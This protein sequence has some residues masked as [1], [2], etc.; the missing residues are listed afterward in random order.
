MKSFTKGISVKLKFLTVFALT[1]LSAE[2]VHAQCSPVP[3]ADIKAEF[4]KNQRGEIFITDPDPTVKYHWYRDGDMKDM[5]YGIDGSGRHLVTS[6]DL[7]AAESYW[8]KK[9]INSTIGPGVIAQNNG[10]SAP[11]D[12]DARTYE[13]AFDA[14][15]DFTLNSVKVP[16]L[17]YQNTPTYGLQ[18]TVRSSTGTLL[19]SGWNKFKVSSSNTWQT[20]TVPANIAVPKGTGY[21]I[22]LTSLTDAALG[23]TKID[24]I[25]W[26]P[27]FLVL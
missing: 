4:C 2:N 27:T 25:Y 3:A 15:I 21:T 19:Y 26:Y 9:E 14:S 20:I 22:Q 12:Q 24:N 17:V 10:S 6:N 16:V 23:I 8:Y 18:I 13:M 11:I 1:V 5:F 7:T